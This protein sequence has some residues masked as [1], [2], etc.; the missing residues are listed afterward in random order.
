MSNAIQSFGALYNNPFIFMPIFLSFYDSLGEKPRSILLS[1][2][3][4]PLVL[5]PESHSFLVK[6]IPR[7]SMKTL[8]EANSRNSK[9]K[10]EKI[11][12]RSR[13]YGIEERIV[14][15]RDLTNA[16]LQYAVDVSILDIDEDLSVEVTSDWHTTPICSPE[17]LKAAYNLGRLFKPYDVP[18][19]YRNLG[20]KRL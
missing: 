6:A 15:Y 20:V 16:S 4:L 2:L 3:V 14:G 17:Q 13:I 19:I 5:Y 11:D 1:Y 12:K 10:M 18:T 8:V 7:S 9:E